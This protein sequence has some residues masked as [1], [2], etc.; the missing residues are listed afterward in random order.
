LRT[1]GS[2]IHTFSRPHYNHNSFTMM[3]SS[4]VGPAYHYFLPSAL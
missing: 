3:L 1:P 2:D 4:T